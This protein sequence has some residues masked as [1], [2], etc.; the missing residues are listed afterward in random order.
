MNLEKIRIYDNLLL[1]GRYQ[2]F[3]QE[4]RDPWHYLLDAHTETE[5][6]QNQENNG[7]SHGSNGIDY[8]CFYRDMIDFIEG[9]LS[10][11]L[12]ALRAISQVFHEC[13]S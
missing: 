8:H 6:T 11:L 12:Y 2:S 13:I 1:T 9:M 5:F 10:H 7:V 3:R 4:A